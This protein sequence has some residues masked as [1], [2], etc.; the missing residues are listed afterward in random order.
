MS[1]ASATAHTPTTP[2]AAIPSV[3]NLTGLMPSELE[4]TLTSL[5]SNR[6][7]LGYML[8]SRSQPVT[9]IRH[10]GVV[11]DGEQGR[12]YAGVV[13]RVVESVRVGL[14]EVSGDLG[15][16]VSMINLLG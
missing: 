13:S 10:S 9:I 14:E 3:P 5:S 12:N 8:L 15:D 16:T 4:H 1:T 2:L 7:V 11:F 6:T